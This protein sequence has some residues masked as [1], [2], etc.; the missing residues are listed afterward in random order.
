MSAVE[1][2]DRADRGRQ[3]LE[4]LGRHNLRMLG[5]SAEHRA[6]NDLEPRRSV[7]DA[8]VRPTGR[9]RDLLQEG[10]AHGDAAT[11]RHCLEHAAGLAA[12][13]LVPGTKSAHHP[14]THGWRGLT[15]AGRRAIRDAGAVMDDLYGS[16][17][18]VTATLTE[19]TAATATRQQIATFQ[20][21]LLFYVRRVQVRR[22]LEPLVLLVCEMHPGRRATDGAL[23]PHWHAVVR[24]SPG[25]YQRWVF[26]KE[27]WNRCVLAA[28]RAAFGHSRGHTQRLSMLP[29][30]T[31]AVRY[32]AKYMGKGSSDVAHLQDSQAGRMV[33]RQ[34]WTWTGELRARVLRC[35]IKPPGPF[36][37]WVCRWWR[38]L[39]DL[40]ELAQTG[41]VQI[42]ERGAV[43]GRWFVWAS[44][45]ALDRAIEGWI[46]EELER[47]DALKTPALATG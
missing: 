11:R 2:A 8:M 27:D 4:R 32:L 1:R 9:F 46:G 47:I 29:Q 40:G 45:A 41:E 6:A 30:K 12:T 36:L 44:E 23:V 38:E 13:A 39:S 25:P 26:R 31:G 24:V 19:E 5:L 16:L 3:E 28:Y 33:P 10:A 37:R 18:F 35:R 21:R 20:Q 7:S 42:G 17:A 15:T 22:R 43:V 14:Q 34:W